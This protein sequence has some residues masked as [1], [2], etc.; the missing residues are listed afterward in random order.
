MD[1][2]ISSYE[3][4][5]GQL[6]AS[7]AEF[8]ERYPKVAARLSISGQRS[9]DP[10]VERMIEAAALLNA[11]ITARLEDDVPEF[12]KPLLEVAYP[13]YLRPFPSCT[14]ACFESSEKIEQL[15]KPAV[16]ERRA[17]LVIP[18]ETDSETE[19][20]TRTEAKTVAENET[21]ADDATKGYHFE[22]AYEVTLAPLRVADAGYRLPSAAPSSVRLPEGTTGIISMTFAAS[23]AGTDLR[24][25][26]PDTL[27]VFVDGD[28]PVVAAAIDAL[29]QRAP[30]AFVE[31]EASGRWTALPQVPV[32]LAGFDDKDALIERA[33]RRRSPFRLLLE[34]FAFPQKFDFI[35]IDF[36]ALLRGAGPRSRVSL[37]VP[38]CGLHPDSLAAR[39]LGALRTTSFRL[40]CTPAINLFPCPSDMV[41]IKDS[42]TL[43]YP[44]VP[45]R[46]SL[47]RTA[48]WTVDAVRAQVQGTNGKSTVTVPGFESLGHSAGTHRPGKREPFFWRVERDER[49]PDF[50]AGQ[51]ALL[52]FVGLDGRLIEPEGIE[53]IDVDLRCTNRN[54]PAEINPGKPEGDF[55]KA[56]YDSENRIVMLRKPTA[57]L[58]RPEKPGRYWNLV[59]M[60][61]P[62]TF[63]L[64]QA[65]LPALKELL[66]GHVPQVSQP[67]ARHIDAIV[68]LASETAMEWIVE[69]PLSR[70]ERGLRVR[71]SI[72]DSVLSGYALSTFAR[73]LESVFVR[74]APENSFAQLVL[75]SAHNGSELARGQLLRGTSALV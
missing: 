74:Y 45:A 64:N 48:V 71:L 38:V 19:A 9:E 68:G 13:E 11:R 21:N 37:H 28:Q 26:A 57:S 27:R 15:T 33:G 62:S 65:G 8:A 73:V 18:I 2:L 34:Y 25:V 49:L 46:L 41:S 61:S 24:R 12:T 30:G 56:G 23:I 60:L 58:P 44:L 3:R 67:A 5:L 52:S 7:L 40:S 54:L 50:L 55:R 32:S 31:V 63:S 42:T 59:T 29:L 36:A 20:K 72:D 10:Q 6:R 69:E 22:T 14:I 53:Q 35:D 39:S 16:I 75:V 47:E 43:V 70:L 51:D 17:K 1:D 4:E 66:S